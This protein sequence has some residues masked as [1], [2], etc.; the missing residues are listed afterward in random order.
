MLQPHAQLQQTDPK[1]VSEGSGR[2]DPHFHGYKPTAAPGTL[3]IGTHFPPVLG[4]RAQLL[5]STGPAPQESFPLPSHERQ[6]LSGYFLNQVKRHFCLRQAPPGT[7]PSPALSPCQS[8]DQPPGK[9]YQLEF[10]FP[11]LCTASS[12]PETAHPSGESTGLGMRAPGF[13]WLPVA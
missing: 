10:N 4:S 6:V 11:V 12:F 1:R 3:P 5:A 8:C 2:A 9:G 7:G 13:P